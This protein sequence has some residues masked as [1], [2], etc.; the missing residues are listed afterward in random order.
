MSQM[1]SLTDSDVE[2]DDNDSD[3]GDSTSVATICVPVPINVFLSPEVET[4]LASHH[5]ASINESKK[6]EDM[7]KSESNV[8]RDRKTAVISQEETESA[9]NSL[10]SESFDSFEGLA[11]PDRPKT[12]LLK[13]KFSKSS[14]EVSLIPTTT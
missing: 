5:I 1:P 13:D 12:E 11:D 6:S 3:P 9:V 2:G 8:E 7:S 14:S 4:Q 10:L